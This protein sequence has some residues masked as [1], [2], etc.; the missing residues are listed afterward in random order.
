VV[1]P[2]GAVLVEADEHPTI[3]YADIGRSTVPEVIELYSNVSASVQILNYSRVLVQ[4][5][6]SLRSVDS[7]YTPTWLKESS[8]STRRD[9]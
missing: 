7:M 4:G 5:S 8:N 1:A 3:V 2:N 9:S 6:P